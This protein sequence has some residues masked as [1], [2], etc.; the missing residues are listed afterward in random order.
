MLLHEY[1]ICLPF[2]IEEYHIG[3][4]YMICKHCEI[5]SSKD[6]GVE[7][8]RNEPITNE[9]GLV[10]QLTEKRLYLSSRLPTWI[11]SLIPNLFYIT[12]KASNFYPYTTT[13]YTCSFLPRFSI[14]VETRYENNNGTTENC[15]SLSP[16]ELAIR[17]LEYLD[18]AIE[19]I[20]D[21]KYKE[22]EDPCKFKST[23]TGRGPLT[24]T[25]RDYMKP[26]MCAYKTVRVRFE[27][28]GFQTRV[29][30]FT[31]RAV[32]DILILAHRQ[33]FTWMDEWYGMSM[34]Q[35]REY[36]REMFERTNKKVLQS[37]APIISPISTPT[38]TNNTIFD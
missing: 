10:G 24:A 37:T 12:E 15:H 18:I 1:R 27:V 31:Q 34:D 23:K 20:P 11:R 4:L 36:E 35:V 38:T 32:R 22:S 25:W 19:R 29:E 30:D 8:V 5:E 3:Q 26:I 28:W 6:E 7:V 13:E 14:M 2:T 33:A 9:N 16:D 21:Y 17:K